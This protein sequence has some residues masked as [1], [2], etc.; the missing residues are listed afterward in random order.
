MAP[1]VEAAA[2]S[3]RAQAVAVGYAVFYVYV[4]DERMGPGFIKI[5]SYFPYPV[6]VYP[7]GHEWASD[8]RPRPGSGSGSPRRPTGSRLARTQPGLQDICDR[9]GPG[10]VQVWFERWIARIPLPLDREAAFALLAER[11]SALRVFVSASS[12]PR[13]GFSAD[14][15]AA[16]TS[17]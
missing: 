5:C 15:Y 8:R 13:A 12:S 7:N 17:S 14:V 6:R 16:P 4:F 1:D 11:C 2:A 9:F 3:G 10:A